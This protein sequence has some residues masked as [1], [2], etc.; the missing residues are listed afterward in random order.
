M[1]YI[2]YK[3]WDNTGSTSTKIHTTTSDAGV[4]NFLNDLEKEKIRNGENYE[5]YLIVQGQRYEHKKINQ[6]ILEKISVC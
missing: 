1:W 5:V 4:T 2:A 3:Q 6:F